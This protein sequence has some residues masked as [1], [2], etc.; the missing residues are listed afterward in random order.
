MSWVFKLGEDAS[1]YAV[2]LILQL[3]F[4]ITVGLLSLNYNIILNI[5]VH[6]Q[7]LLCYYT[8]KLSVL[9]ADVRKL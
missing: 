4:K 8:N 5:R 9:L 2:T 6:I 3:A 1:L 7:S